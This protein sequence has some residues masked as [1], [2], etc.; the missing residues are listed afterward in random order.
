MIERPQDET[1]NHTEN[2]TGTSLARDCLVEVRSLIWKWTWDWGPVGGWTIKLKCSLENAGR[3]G[4]QGRDGT[5]AW[6][7]DCRAKLKEGREIMQELRSLANLPFLIQHW[8]V[9]DIWRQC[10]DLIIIVQGGVACLE[11]WISLADVLPAPV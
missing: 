10:F 5:R 1:T 9:Q 3:H 4:T 7:C 6:I 2:T 11:A 8:E